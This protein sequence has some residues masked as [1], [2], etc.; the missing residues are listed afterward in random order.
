MKRRIK[1]KN[2]GIIGL[3]IVAI[4]SIIV[5]VTRKPNDPANAGMG[6]NSENISEIEF[7]EEDVIEIGDD[8]SEGG[9]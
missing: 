2:V 7:Q 6:D 8:E 4:I 9:F 5:F 3:C 1:W